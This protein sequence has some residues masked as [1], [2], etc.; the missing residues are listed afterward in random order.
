MISGLWSLLLVMLIKCINYKIFSESWSV[1]STGGWGEAFEKGIE[2]LI[3]LNH[4]LQQ[5]FPTFS[6]WAWGTSSPG[7]VSIKI[8]SYKYITI[9]K[10]FISDH[11]STVDQ[12]EISLTCEWC[13]LHWSCPEGRYQGPL[14]CRPAWRSAGGSGLR[15]ASAAGCHHYA[16]LFFRGGFS[17]IKSSI[18]SI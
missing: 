8:L 4:H 14:P 7:R 13:S 16:Y 2:W 6:Q 3:D 10:S 1:Y 17:W 5:S 15:A 12:W 11:V 18:S 9:V